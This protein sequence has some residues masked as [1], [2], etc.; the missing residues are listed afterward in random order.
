MFVGEDFQ[1]TCLFNGFSYIADGYLFKFD[2]IK[3]HLVQWLLGY[4]RL[5]EVF[6]NYWCQ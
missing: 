4:L 5:I 3:R 1:L 6:F 2:V